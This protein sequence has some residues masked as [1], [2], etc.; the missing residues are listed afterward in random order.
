[1]VSFLSDTR[2]SL[3]GLTRSPAFTAVAILIL[4]LG[5]GINAAIFSVV[6]ALFFRSL[7]VPNPSALVSLGFLTKGNP[8]IPTTSYPDLQDIRRQGGQ[9]VDVFAYRMG[10]TALSTGDSANR[11]LANYVSG[12]YFSGLGVKPAL[13]RLILPS[14]GRVPGSDPVMVLGYS[15][16]KTHFAGDPAVIGRTVHV[17]GHPVT[18]VGVAQKGFH[19]VLGYMNVQAYLPLNLIEGG[20]TAAD[21]SIRNL[22]V[23]GRLRPGVKRL[24]ADAGMK[25]IASRLARTYPL[26]DPDANIWLLP[27]KEAMLTPFPKPGQ[28]QQELAVVSL[29]LA[30]ALLIFVVVCLTSPTSCWSASLRGSTR[31]RSAWPWALLPAA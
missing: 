17:D 12:D 18:I 1:M 22:F 19:G 6:D 26:T 10:M 24:Q 28:Y 3:G 5:I 13:G 21:R 2:S 29:F 15:Y 16:W 7:P 27:Q 11:V 31:W 8:G 23:L 25:V 14:E 4:A 30:L 9:W 20:T